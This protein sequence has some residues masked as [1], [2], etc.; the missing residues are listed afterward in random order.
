M[1]YIYGRV[2]AVPTYRVYQLYDIEDY[3]YLIVKMWLIIQ[4]THEKLN[5]EKKNVGE[6]NVSEVQSAAVH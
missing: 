1:Y 2:Q 5:C 6:P 3:S 4:V